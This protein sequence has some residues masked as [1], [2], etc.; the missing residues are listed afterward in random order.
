MCHCLVPPMEVSWNLQDGTSTLNCSLQL[1]T[2]QPGLEGD[3][4]L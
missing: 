2:E 3:V 1:E 4:H